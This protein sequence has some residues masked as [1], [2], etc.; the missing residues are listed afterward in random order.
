MRQNRTFEKQIR[1]ARI[2]GEAL[3]NVRK[4]KNAK[5]VND[6]PRPGLAPPMVWG[7]VG[8]LPFLSFPM[9]KTFLSEEAVI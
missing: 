5:Q 2:L 3:R 6:W 8:H 1:A 7:K 9:K 4:A